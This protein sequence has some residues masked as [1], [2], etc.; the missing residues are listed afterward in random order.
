[1]PIT[2]SVALQK[3]GTGKTT[4]ATAIADILSAQHNKRVLLVDMD[5][6]CNATFISNIDP[7][8]TI[9]DVLAGDCSITEA[10]YKCAHYDLLPADEFLVNIEKADELES[11]LLRNAI[12]AVADQYDYIIIDTPPA[13]GNILMNCLCASDYVIIPIE[14]RPLAIKGLQALADTINAVKEV[15]NKLE[16]LGVLLVK[17]HDRTVLNRQMKE[18]LADQVHEL[19]DTTLFETYIREGVAIAEA[20]TMQTSILDYNPSSNPCIDYVALTNEIIQRIEG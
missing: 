11:T 10:I 20:Q 6:Q 1:M 8:R 2:I 17:Y 7:E 9:I 12:A 14:A 15:N 19:L 18:L 5:S 3:G 16:T 13:L 4:T